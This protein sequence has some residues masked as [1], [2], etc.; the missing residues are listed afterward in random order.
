[1]ALTDASLFER[2]CGRLPYVVAA[3]LAL[4][5]SIHALGFTAVWQIWPARP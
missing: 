4:R 3:R 1:M 2:T 5:G